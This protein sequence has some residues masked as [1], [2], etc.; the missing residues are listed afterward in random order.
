M[1]RH[2]WERLISAYYS[3]YQVACKKSRTCLAA[4]FS[5]TALDTSRP[6]ATVTFDEF[7]RA[8][9]LQSPLTLDQHF[10]PATIL[11]ELRRIGYQYI[12]DL[13]SQRHADELAARLALPEA[14]PVKPALAST[15]NGSSTEL[16]SLYEPLPCSYETVAAAES[17]Y[18]EDAQLC[19]YTFAAAYH[20][21]N[22]Y[23]RSAPPLSDQQQD[24]LRRRLGKPR[25]RT[26]TTTATTDDAAGPEQHIPVEESES[27]AFAREQ[28]LLAAAQ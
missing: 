8:I 14:F 25:P 28:E 4:A 17:V 11:C 20:A 22:T 3:K 19:G 10:R 18:G 12:M 5:L 26:S 16:R 21:C 23:G 1:V 7:V 15:V 6:T 9:A 27:A 2:P 13:D 24:E